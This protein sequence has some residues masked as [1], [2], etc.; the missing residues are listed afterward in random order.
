MANTL[1]PEGN[2]T[3]YEVG[4]GGQPALV[5]EPAVSPNIATRKRWINFITIL[6]DEAFLRVSPAFRAGADL[7]AS[8]ASCH[9]HRLP[10]TRTGEICDF[11]PLQ[12]ENLGIV[13]YKK[14]KSFRVGGVGIWRGDGEAAFVSVPEANR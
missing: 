2:W 13:P 10:S 14:Q 8:V 6:S 11:H 9:H 5:K 1:Y 7:V 3:Q 12:K 4:V